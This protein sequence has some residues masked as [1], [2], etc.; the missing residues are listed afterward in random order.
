MKV[1]SK[2]FNEFCIR[3]WIK[4][5]VTVDLSQ[6]LW[7]KIGAKVA[8][9]DSICSFKGINFQTSSVVYSGKLENYYYRRS[10]EF[11]YF[12]NQLIQLN[13]KVM[14]FVINGHQEVGN[15]MSYW[16]GNLED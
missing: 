14:D 9:M 2:N 10:P 16:E 1:L 3:Q 11:S 13:D 15:V 7:G 12:A 4:T 5:H 6:T 8:Y